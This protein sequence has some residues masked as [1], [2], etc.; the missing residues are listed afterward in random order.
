MNKEQTKGPSAMDQNRRNFVKFGAL[1]GLGVAL[2]GMKQAGAQCACDRA[3]HLGPAPAELFRSQPLE[4]IRVGFIGIGGMGGGHLNNYLKIAQTFPV[5]IVAVCDIDPGNLK[6]AADRVVKAGQPEPTQYGERGEYDW[7]RMLDTE[8][9]DL[10]F[11]ATPW[12]WHTPICVKAMETGSH[13]ATEI[14]AALTLEE[15]WQLVETAEKTKK[16]CV[17]M[18]NCNYDSVEM[19][20]LNMVRKGLFGQILHAECGY[21]HDLR[22]VKFSSG[23]EG[24]WRWFHSTQRDGNLYPPHGLGPV[25]QC[26]NINRGD[27]YD[28]L[29]SMSS[30]SVGLQEYV[31]EHLPVTDERRHVTYKLG[32]VNSSLIKTVN[33]CSILV[34]HDTNLPRPYSRKVLVQGSKGIVQKYPEPLI[35]IEGLSEGHGWEPL[36][37]Y[38]E[39]YSHPLL[40]RLKSMAEGAGHG[41]M[42]F[43]EDFRLI[44]CLIKGEPMDM[45]VYDAAALSAVQPLSVA[46]VADRSRPKDC[47]DFT[48]GMWKKWPPLGII[49]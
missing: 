36:S 41:G 38:T 17:M 30:P 33:G 49:E 27:R 21:L 48:R 10:V 12:R 28:Y 6:S 22:G 16:H 18:E 31:R 39:K 5:Q 32:D 40:A 13:A 47:P 43:V 46:S 45:D 4:K 3:P 8:E 9:L 29:V 26:M 42:D 1:G 24:R 15:C 2:A 37:K 19:T 14:P 25:S 44:E 11:T 20:I 23:G 34:V 7:I 35:H